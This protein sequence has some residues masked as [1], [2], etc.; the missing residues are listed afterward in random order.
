MS[1]YYHPC[2]FCGAREGHPEDGG[3]IT[4]A[5]NDA[6]TSPLKWSVDCLSCGAAG[7][8]AEDMVEAVERWNGRKECAS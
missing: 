7:P 8:M 2:P 3:P 4:M 1:D 5:R 6:T